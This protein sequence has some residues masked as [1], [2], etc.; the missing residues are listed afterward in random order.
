MSSNYNCN[1][2]FYRVK[3]I[4]HKRQIPIKESPY[5]V[6]KQYVSFNI[7]P[8]CQYFLWINTWGENEEILSDFQPCFC[9][10]GLL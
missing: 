3:F 1:H 2:K 7:I 10:E 9:A 5:L 4:K 8:L 6:I